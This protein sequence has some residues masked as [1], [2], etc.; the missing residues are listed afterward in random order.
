MALTTYHVVPDFDVGQVVLHEPPFSEPLTVR[1]LP[2][3]IV[4]LTVAL[5]DGPVRR[6]IP[7][8]AGA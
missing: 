1:M 8:Q 6:L 4:V 3:P 7:S 2:I 5:V